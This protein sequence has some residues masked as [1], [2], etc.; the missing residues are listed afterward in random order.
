MTCKALSTGP[1][2]RATSNIGSFEMAKARLDLDLGLQ[3]QHLESPVG[4]IS[5]GGSP[6]ELRSGISGRQ[7]T[8]KE[9]SAEAAIFD[10]RCERMSSVI[11]LLSILGK[12]GDLGIERRQS[13]FSLCYFWIVCVAQVLHSP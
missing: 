1:L 9:D 13:D 10:G 3:T 11:R 5:I 6:R 8:S 2:F 12:Y 7:A 4:N